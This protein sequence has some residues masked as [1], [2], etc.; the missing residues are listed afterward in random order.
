[1]NDVFFRAIDVAT[2]NSPKQLNNTE[3]DVLTDLEIILETHENAI[4]KM[5]A[6]IVGIQD[7][8]ETIQRAISKLEN[9]QNQI[10]LCSDSQER[11]KRE[12][13]SLRLQVSEL[14]METLWTKLRKSWKQWVPLTFIGAII[15]WYSRSK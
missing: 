7:Q 14:E 3:G 11:M 6:D 4:S 10:G 8:L 13:V 12:L 1:M 5:R 2:L 15:L 9:L